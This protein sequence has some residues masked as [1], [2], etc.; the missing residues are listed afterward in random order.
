[1]MIFGI[2]LTR[3]YVNTES[4]QKC[5]AGPNIIAASWEEAKNIAEMRGLILDGLW[6]QNI[7]W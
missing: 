2:F 3:R 7:E 5:L 1:M 4:G 6:I